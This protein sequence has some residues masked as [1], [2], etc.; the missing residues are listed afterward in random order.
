VVSLIPD[1]IMVKYRAKANEAGE[2]PTSRA[3]MAASVQ[4]I[5]GATEKR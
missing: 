5:I 4:S 2:H 3:G 1:E